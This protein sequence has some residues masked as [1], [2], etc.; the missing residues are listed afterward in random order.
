MANME[1]I[2]AKTI[3]TTVGSVTF[4]AIPQTYTD[5]KIMVSARTNYTGA[6]WAETDLTF[7][8]SSSYSS[9]RLQGNG[10]SADSYSSGSVIPFWTQGTAGVSTT[11]TIWGNA[12][13][14]IPNYT[15]SNQKS[16]S[17]DFVNENNATAALSAFNVGLSTLTSAINS[18][19]LTSVNGNY[20]AYSTFYLY[21]I[22]NVTSTTK[23][24]G[25]IVSSDGTYNYHMFPFS[26][27]FTPTQSITV[28]Y[29]A[30]AGGGGGGGIVG[31]GGGAGA[32]AVGTYNLT[33][34]GYTVTV[35]AG[36]IGGTGGVNA[37]TG[38]NTVFHNATVVGGGYGGTH[39]GGPVGQVG[40]AGGSGGGG[41]PSNVASFAGG[42]SN[43]SAITGATIYG[44]AGA[45]GSTGDYPYRGGGGG[46]GNAAGESGET[47]GNG[48]VGFQNTAFAY[49]T[50]TGAN[51]G[52]YAGGGGGAYFAGAPAGVGGS[53][54]GGA[55]ASGTTMAGTAGTANTGGGG[56]AGRDSTGEFTYPGGAGGSGLVIIRYLI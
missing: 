53:G 37:G 50:Q 48:G 41:A 52:Y 34:Q 51:N 16:V 19:T 29:L 38:S 36:G 5:L 49:A 27:T 3:S 28:D 13:I 56:G 35:G 11:D 47:S 32:G 23:A 24:T 15:S 8:G 17:I 20:V 30:V 7:N 40:G 12:E 45:V 18:I 55:G 2:E 10:S 39:Q 25:G 26:S 43:Q 33:A 54:G 9:I 21:G 4:S 44:N 42:A 1:L 14:Y 46:G 6:P 22:S 31:G